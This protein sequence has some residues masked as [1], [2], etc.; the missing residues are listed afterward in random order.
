[1]EKSSIIRLLNNGK[2]GRNCIEGIIGEKSCAGA[3]NRGKIA[4]NSIHR[5]AARGW[6]PGAI[7]EM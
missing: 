6:Q 2:C 5:L 3:E 1:M 7:S 4:Q